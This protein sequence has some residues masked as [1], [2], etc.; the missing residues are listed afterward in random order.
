MRT[1]Q[2]AG[3]L[4]GGGGL[5]SAVSGGDQLGQ[6]WVNVVAIGVD[7]IP[8]DD[9]AQKT[10]KACDVEEAEMIALSKAPARATGERHRERADEER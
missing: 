5:T 10:Q 9:D 1:C 3:A 6:Q 2:T 4:E 8:D 7:A